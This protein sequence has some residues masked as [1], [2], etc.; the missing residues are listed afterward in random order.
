MRARCYQRVMFEDFTFTDVLGILGSLT[1]CSA[2]FAISLGRL[3][4]EKA[5]FHV[6]NIAGAAMLLISLYFRPNPGA[7]LIEV[8]WVAIAV[9]ALTRIWLKR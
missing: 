2:Y 3:N 7:I 5:P 9:I 8:L 1:I 6:V 4:A